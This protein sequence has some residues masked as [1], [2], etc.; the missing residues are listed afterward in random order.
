MCNDV[1]WKLLKTFA[2]IAVSAGQLAFNGINRWHRNIRATVTADFEVV[3]TRVKDGATYN[4]IITKDTAGDV[5]VTLPA[6]SVI[7]NSAE[8]TFTLTGAS[9]LKYWL[10]FTYV[11][12]EYVWSLN[13]AG[14][15]SANN[16]L[17]ITTVE[18]A[19]YLLS[20]DDN[21]S[22]IVMDTTAPRNITIP[23]GLPV[24]FNCAVIQ[25][26]IGAIT[27]LVSGGMVLNEPDGLNGTNMP[28]ARV[29]IIH[30]GGELYNLGGL[31]G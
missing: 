11:N 3:P 7:S 12:E 28:H 20:E 13:G 4:L 6:G 15:S 10:Q 16:G 30:L 26:N 29:S 23:E 22:V 25:Q 31:T 2:S 14:S 21:N 24:G 1:N 5:V 18:E 9:G 19:N 17:T 27:F 8:T